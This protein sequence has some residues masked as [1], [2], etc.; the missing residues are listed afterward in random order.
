MVLLTGGGF[1]KNSDFENQGMSLASDTA[2]YSGRLRTARDLDR[3][4][5]NS[6]RRVQ[7][8]HIAA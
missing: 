2:S 8:K 3:Q 5:V 7:Q 1:E 4:A 6:A